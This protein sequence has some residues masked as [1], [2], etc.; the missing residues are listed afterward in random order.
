M[1]F[2][3]TRDLPTAALLFS[4]PDIQFL[5]LEGDN[6]RSLYFLFGPHKK[7]ERLALNFVAGRVSVNARVYADAFRRSKDVLFEAERNNQ[8]PSSGVSR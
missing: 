4:F 7:A 8:R 1:N 2:F 6:P 5:G 3:R